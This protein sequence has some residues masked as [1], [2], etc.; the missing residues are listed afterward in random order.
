MGYT[1]RMARA[2]RLQTVAETKAFAEDIDAMLPSAERD[3]VIK[4]IAANPESG[5]L[6]RGTGGL[7]KRRIALPGRGKRGGAR[8]ITLFLGEQFPVYAVF[9][10][11]KNEREN[12]SAEQTKVLLRLVSAIKE[13]ARTS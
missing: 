13:Q 10:Y 11:A 7:R 12:L 3:A 2:R 9:L 4:D 5:D 6:I 1:R 8:V